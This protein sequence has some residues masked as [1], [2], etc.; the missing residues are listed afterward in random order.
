MDEVSIIGID[1]AK[2]SFQL[3]GARADGSVVVPQ[4]AEAGEATEL[5]CLCAAL[6]GGDGGMRERALLG[7]GDHGAG[8]RGAAG[9]ADLRESPS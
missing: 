5:R 1:L 4:D 2:R 3:H 9:S 8:P 6:C 7:P